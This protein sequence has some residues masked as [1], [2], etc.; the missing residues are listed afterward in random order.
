MTGTVERAAVAVF[1]P[2]CRR[3]V[4]VFGWTEH[5]A[6]TKSYRRYQGSGSILIG[7]TVSAADKATCFSCGAALA[8]TPVDLQRRA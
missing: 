2:G 4:M 7:T 1:C 3:D 5:Q 6:Q 8:L